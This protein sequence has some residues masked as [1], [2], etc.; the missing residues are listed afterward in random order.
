MSIRITDSYLSA[1]MVGNMN[2]SL[3]SL[4]EQQRMAGSLQRV[5]SY[6]DDPRSV[7]I[8]QR[9][10]SL[11]SQNDSY[12]GNVSRSRTLVDGTDIALQDLSE[13]LADARVIA[14]RESSSL[15]NSET[16]TNSAFEIENLVGRMMEVL[17]TSIEGHYLF[18]GRETNTPPF[19][20][21]GGTV[22]YLG[23]GGIITG[24]TGPHS[25]MPLNIPGD[26]FMGSQAASLAGQTQLGPFLRDTTLLADINQGDGWSPGSLAITLGNGTIH[27]VD[28]ADAVTVGDVISRITA[29]TKELSRPLFPPMAGE[30]P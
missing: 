16:M 9:L 4:L 15:A 29:G 30:S 5:N 17:N 11:I 23:D 28:L 25:T 12:L 7:S 3:N 27:Q 20:L 22:S 18:A 19:V 2:R 8:I 10:N 6:A 14:L 1:I 24:R 21:N 13:I 26:I